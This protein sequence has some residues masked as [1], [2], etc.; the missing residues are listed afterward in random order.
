M[1]VSA[2]S[3]MQ[4]SATEFATN[5][6]QD[7]AINASLAS[8]MEATQ[9]D[10]TD[11]MAANMD[12]SMSS[13]QMMQMAIALIILQ[14]INGGGSGGGSESGTDLLG[15]L[16]A[17]A[18]LQSANSGEATLEGTSETSVKL[19]QTTSF[20]YASQAYNTQSTDTPVDTPDPNQP[21]TN[22]DVLI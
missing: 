11:M 16:N 8:T 15:M 20:N 22:V 13:E 2:T 21:L 9:F 14:M 12:S 3:S 10:G 5:M 4:Y 18:L 17:D 19:E 6:S 1:N 7:P